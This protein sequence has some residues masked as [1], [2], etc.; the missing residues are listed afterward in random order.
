MSALKGTQK[1]LKKS[2]KITADD[3]SWAARISWAY[4]VDHS[5]LTHVFEMSEGKNMS[6]EM[7]LCFVRYLKKQAEKIGMKTKP[8]LDDMIIAGRLFKGAK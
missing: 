2:K 5:F 8:D 1:K 3:P 6:A 7:F 4:R